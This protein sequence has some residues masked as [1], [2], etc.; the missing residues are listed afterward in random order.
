MVKNVPYLPLTDPKRASDGATVA[1]AAY[2]RA[3]FCR[4]VCQGRMWKKTKDTASGGG[5]EWKRRGC[6]D[7][8]RTDRKEGREGN[9]EERGSNKNALS[10]SRLF[11]SGMD[12]AGGTGSR[13][14]A[15]AVATISTMK[16]EHLFRPG[17]WKSL[18]PSGTE[19]TRDFTEPA[20]NF[21]RVLWHSL[22]LSLA[23]SPSGVRAG[24]R[25]SEM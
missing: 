25:P 4:H 1:M 3:A 5:R 15:G 22:S 21:R 23:A 19:V 14:G 16:W 6:D 18:P 10:Q 20:S 2:V 8:P 24:R 7:S 17:P 13:A 9:K 11:R 12:L